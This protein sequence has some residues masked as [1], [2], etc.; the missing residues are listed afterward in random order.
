MLGHH[1]GIS[2]LDCVG[3]SLDA[4]IDSPAFPGPLCT[5]VSTLGDKGGL[6]GGERVFKWASHLRDR[7]YRTPYLAYDD[8]VC[9]LQRTFA[10]LVDQSGGQGRDL[11]LSGS[12]DPSQYIRSLTR[13]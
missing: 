13:D 11:K 8:S 1:R 7:S 10:H 5:V 9:S 2:S 3:E 4:S 12:T 6:S